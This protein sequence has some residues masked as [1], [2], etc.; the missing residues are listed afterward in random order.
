MYDVNRISDVLKEYIDVFTMK[1]EYVNIGILKKYRID[2]G[3]N[4]EYDNKKWCMLFRKKSALNYCAKFILLR[5][6][7]DKNEITTKLNYEGLKKWNDLVKNIQTRYELLYNI[8]IED[9]INDKENMDFRHIFSKTDYDIYNMDKDLA[10][11][12]IDGFAYMNFNSISNYEIVEVFRN[13]YSLDDREEYNLQEFYR[14]AP[15][16]EYILKIEY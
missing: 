12:I 11:I 15:A 6:Y 8:A 5:L 16:L 14:S 13:I 1:Y 7:E 9:I 10:E 4:L 2:S 3:L